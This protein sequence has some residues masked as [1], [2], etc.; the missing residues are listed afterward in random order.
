MLEFIKHDIIRPLERT[1][2]P[3]SKI[4]FDNEKWA[5][6][7]A[8]QCASIEKLPK[9][10]N[11][12]EYNFPNRS[13]GDSEKYRSYFHKTDSI[14]IRVP[15]IKRKEEKD[16]FLNLKKKIGPHTE[17]FKEGW[18]PQGN[19]KTMN[20]R[21]SVG[22]NILSN[23]NNPISGGLVLKILD[24]K[25]T[26]KKKGVAEFSDLS[27]PFNPN[28]SKKFRDNHHEN[29]KIFHV[30]NGIFS[31]MYDA[32]HRN[33]NIVVPFRNNTGATATMP[34]ESHMNN[35][36]GGNQKTYSKSPKREK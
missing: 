15:T 2:E 29:N 7:T 13:E 33:G 25:L 24:N 16:S 1:K 11:Y 6:G 10:Q 36:R 9:L 26:N 32:A 4:N 22:Y 20:N 18:V 8:K 14:A 3:G 19:F 27:H 31:H 34:I 28:A 21:S 12:R 17:T 5:V 35:A 23:D 30:Y